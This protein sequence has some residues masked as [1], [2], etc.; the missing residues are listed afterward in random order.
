MKLDR[1]D[2]FLDKM[3]LL[4][5]L[6]S[7]LLLLSLIQR[8]DAGLQVAIEQADLYNRQNLHATRPN[9]GW[10][11]GKLMKRQPPR[12]YCLTLSP[13]SNPPSAPSPPLLL[14]SQRMTQAQAQVLPFLPLGH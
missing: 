12:Y 7:I 1:I 2:T 14:P 10:I 3:K 9:Q 6:I 11:V 5:T 4:L 13:L 8:T